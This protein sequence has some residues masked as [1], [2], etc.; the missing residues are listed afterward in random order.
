MLTLEIQQNNIHLNKVILLSKTIIDNNREVNIQ[1][2]N[3]FRIR[4][5]KCA[6]CSTESYWLDYP[7]FPDREITR[8]DMSLSNVV[9]YILR[10]HFVSYSDIT[11]TMVY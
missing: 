10:T 1:F 6:Y 5:A 11:V 3:D 8:L 9:K 4:I 7:D 2:S